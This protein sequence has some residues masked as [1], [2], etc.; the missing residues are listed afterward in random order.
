MATKKTTSKKAP[1]K[2][3][4]TVKRASAKAQSSSRLSAVRLQ[5]ETKPF[6]TFQ[7]TKETVYWIVLGAVV[8]LFT[9]WLMRLQMDIQSL[10]D[11]IDASNLS[12]TTKSY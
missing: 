4:S 10:Y 8:I 9:I 1:T 12:T 11:D 2:K 6:M 3:K 5:P 7:L